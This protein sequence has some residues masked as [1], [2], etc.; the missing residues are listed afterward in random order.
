MSSFRRELAKYTPLVKSVL[1]VFGV[2]KPVLDGMDTVGQIAGL[3][4]SQDAAVRHLADD[5]AR[6]LESDSANE[7]RNVGDA[8]R[9]YLRS[10]LTQAL[11]HGD[12]AGLLVAAVDGREALELHLRR[13]PAVLAALSEWD[14]WADPPQ[15]FVGLVHQVSAL[16]VGWVRSDQ[17]SGL[18][19]LE[20]VAAN[21]R[22]TAASLDQLTSVRQDLADLPAAIARALDARGDQRRLADSD[23]QLPGTITQHV[24][25]HAQGFIGGVH[26]HYYGTSTDVG[27]RPDSLD[28][29]N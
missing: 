15:Y 29:P 25:D 12:H 27:A 28:E 6:V 7:Y 1:G 16:L 14:R 10:T 24:T 20:A 3:T 21:L 8:D 23:Q 9:E 11:E 22:A 4:S 2:P 5:A 13:N 26:T 17:M 18:A 19:T